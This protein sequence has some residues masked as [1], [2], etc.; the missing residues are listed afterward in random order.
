MPTTCVRR[1]RPRPTPWPSACSSAAIAASVARAVVLKR[2]AHGELP[3]GREGRYLVALLL[4]IV[5]S[6]RNA[7]HPAALPHGG[8]LPVLGRTQQGDLRVGVHGAGWV[9]LRLKQATV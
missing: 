6:W 5:C 3:G 9:S 8:L 1:M 2:L 7:Q 4:G